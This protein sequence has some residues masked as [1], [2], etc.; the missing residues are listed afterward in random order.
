VNEQ[1]IKLAASAG[2]VV[3]MII[4]AG[5]ARIARP[6]APLDESSARDLLAAEFPDRTPDLLWV[7]GDGAGVVARAGADALVLY[8][9]GDSWVARTMPWRLALAA[10]VRRGKVL[11]KLRDPA[12]PMA[13]LAV[14]GV[15]PWPPEILQEG[16]AA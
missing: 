10:P 13:R 15:T 3:F 6:V 9:L 11:L 1:L 5:L 8:R 2:F 4:V 14:S 7:A 12:A 16:L